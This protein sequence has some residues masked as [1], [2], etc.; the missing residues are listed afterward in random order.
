MRVLNTKDYNKHSGKFS[1]PGFRTGSFFKKIVACLYY[2]L[3]LVFAI[4]S[5]RITVSGDFGG[6]TD[7][8][9]A[10]VVELL[11][12]L[13]LVT[14]V[15]AIGFSDYYDWHGIKLF[16]IILVSWCVLFTAAQFVSTLFSND[17]INSTNSSFTGSAGEV[18]SDGM[19]D[20]INTEI[21]KN[22]IKDNIDE[23][24]NS[25]SSDKN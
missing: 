6:G 13:I 8:F 18:M 1:L 5:I 22:I 15:I 7:I 25:A 20:N 14:P 16:L 21:D 9:L 10:V 3:I 11:I 17:F 2:V 12:V 19:E 4:N 24:N 23:I